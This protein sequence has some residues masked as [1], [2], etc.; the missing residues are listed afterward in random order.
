MG[1]FGD[2]DV[3]NHRLPDGS[4]RSEARDN[5]WLSF[6]K[7]KGPSD[8]FVQS[9]VWVPG[10]STGWHTHPGH[11]LIIVT[12]GTVTVYDADDPSCTPQ[13]YTVGM[14]LVDAGGDHIHLLRNEDSVEARAADCAA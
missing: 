6:Q 8:L 7:T 1:R 2:I 13:V 9:N 3:S 4:R 11:S 14:G 10:G 12:A 5:F